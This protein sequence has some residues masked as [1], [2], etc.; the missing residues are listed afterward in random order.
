MS[1]TIYT[2]HWIRILWHCLWKSMYNF[3][4]SNSVLWYT[5][6]YCPVQSPTSHL[7]QYIVVNFFT[8][9][10]VWRLLLSALTRHGSWD[11]STLAYVAGILYTQ[12]SSPTSLLAGLLVGPCTWIP[13]LALAS[14]PSANFSWKIYSNIFFLLVSLC[15]MCALATTRLNRWKETFFHHFIVFIS[16]E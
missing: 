12:W 14:K 7:W 16:N 8:I 9:F 6:K 15:K 2:L 1:T 13:I 11:P 10:L 5:S 4:P 3:T